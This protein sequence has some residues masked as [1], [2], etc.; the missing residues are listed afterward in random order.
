MSAFHCDLSRIV[1]LDLAPG[2]L[3]ALEWKELGRGVGIATLKRDGDTALVLYR[4]AEDAPQD[5][6]TS[7]H[8]PGGELYLVLKGAIGDEDGTYGAGSLVWLPP[9]SRHT[10]RARGA[11]IVLV[12]WPGG[13]R[14]D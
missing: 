14:L 4:V 12:L 10:P 8:H 11:T 6:F 2:A 7:H 1:G 3:D 13:V 5:A 9:G